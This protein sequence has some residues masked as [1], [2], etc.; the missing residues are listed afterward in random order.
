MLDNPRAIQ[1]TQAKFASFISSS[2]VALL[3]VATKPLG[4]E[5]D[6]TDYFDAEY[7]GKMGYGVIDRDSIPQLIWWSKH[8]GSILGEV[9]SIYQIVPRFYLFHQGKLTQNWH[10]GAAQTNPETADAALVLTGLGLLMGSR[11]MVRG[12]GDHL[13]SQGMNAL[14]NYFDPVIQSLV[15]KTKA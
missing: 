6:I 14:L 2:E 8:F 11:S 3:R 12:V 5:R 9:G 13:R 7:P 4:F 10:S 15:N 1:V